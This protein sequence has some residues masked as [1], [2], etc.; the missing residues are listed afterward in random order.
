MLFLVAFYLFCFIRNIVQFSVTLEQKK[1]KKIYRQQNKR[2]RKKKRKERW[3]LQNTAWE[4]KQLIFSRICGLSR[5]LKTRCFSWNATIW[6]TPKWT[7]ENRRLFQQS[8]L[9]E[10]LFSFLQ[11]Y[12]GC[13][14]VYLKRKN[15]LPVYKVASV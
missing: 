3:W 8:R 13:V 15:K 5:L 14:R 7:T 11:I 1:I 2:Q 10:F 6:L 9:L 4:F 12:M